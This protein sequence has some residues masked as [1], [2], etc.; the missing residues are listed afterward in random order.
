MNSQNLSFFAFITPRLLR[1][2][3]NSV[4]L[5]FP[6]FFLNVEHDSLRLKNLICKQ[7]QKLEFNV[8]SKEEGRVLSL[9]SRIWN[10]RAI[11]DATSV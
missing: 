5:F 11:K 10:F 2:N 7:A 8:H 9:R 1:D 6:A 3:E 4:P